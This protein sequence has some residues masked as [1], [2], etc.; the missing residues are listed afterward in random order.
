MTRPGMLKLFQ[1]HCYSP[2]MRLPGGK[3]LIVKEF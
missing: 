1:R 2:K 3:L